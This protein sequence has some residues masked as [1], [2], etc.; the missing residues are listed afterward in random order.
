MEVQ[1]ETEVELWLEARQEELVQKARW[2][3]DKKMKE[4]NPKQWKKMKTKRL[5]DQMTKL[6]S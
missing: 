3:A 5:Q 1:H 6:E 2:E 4:T